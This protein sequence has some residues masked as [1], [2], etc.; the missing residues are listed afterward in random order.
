[1]SGPCLFGFLQNEFCTGGPSVAGLGGPSPSG[2][3][4]SSLDSVLDNG[5]AYPLIKMGVSLEGL[6]NFCLGLCVLLDSKCRCA[7]AGGRA[8]C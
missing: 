7:F 2:S 6:L 1:M 5:V 8:K 4:V 3:R